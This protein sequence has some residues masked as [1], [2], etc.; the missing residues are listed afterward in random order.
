MRCF[1]RLYE[2]IT[3]FALHQNSA[4]RKYKAINIQYIMEGYSGITRDCI[5]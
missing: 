5:V 1:K 3:S 4:H 2:S